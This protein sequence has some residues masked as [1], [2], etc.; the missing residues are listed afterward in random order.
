MKP[1][2]SKNTLTIFDILST[3]VNKKEA[4]GPFQIPQTDK[5]FRYSKPAILK[6]GSIHALIESGEIGY[7]QD[8][9]NSKT[10]SLSYSKQRA[11]A[12]LLPFFVRLSPTQKPDIAL[13][14]SQKFRTFGVKTHICQEL[15]KELLQLDPSWVLKIEKIIPNDLINKYLTDGI[16]KNIRFISHEKPSDIAND[17]NKLASDD[18]ASTIELVVKARRGSSF[19]HTL[20]NLVKGKQP[21][22]GLVTLPQVAY[23]E[24]KVDIEIGGR[25]KTLDLTNMQKIGAVIDVTKELAL[26]KNGHPTIT[27]LIDSSNSL[28]AGIKAQI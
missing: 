5:V 13:F 28:I 6:D 11:E 12:G 20:L 17:L 24:V 3:L 25:H 14:I 19:G 15:G 4:G 18:D 23:T 27:S 7:N 1:A 8:I 26:D 9:I 21:L 2:G 22:T 16:V 10:G